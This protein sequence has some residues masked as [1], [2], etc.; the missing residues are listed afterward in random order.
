[1]GRIMRWC[2]P[3][4]ALHIGTGV[5]LYRLIRD[6]LRARSIQAH[7]DFQKQYYG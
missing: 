5:S 1:M 3:D 7:A 6:E 2:V 4:R